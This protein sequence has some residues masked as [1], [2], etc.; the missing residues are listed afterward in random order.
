MKSINQN[1]SFAGPDNK[2]WIFPPSAE[3]KDF[4]SGNNIALLYSGDV[5]LER[6]NAFSHS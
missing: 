2:P 6:K 4:K 5:H 3:K 1:V